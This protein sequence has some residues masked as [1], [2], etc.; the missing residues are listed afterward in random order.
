MIAV[1]EEHDS[2]HLEQDL[3][4][5]KELIASGINP[6]I[7][8]SHFGRLRKSIS[9]CKHDFHMPD[10]ELIRWL[11]ERE[12]LLG[13]F[14][15]FSTPEELEESCRALNFFQP[16]TFQHLNGEEAFVGALLSEPQC[17]ALLN[18]YTLGWVNQIR[19]RIYSLPSPMTRNNTFHL[20]Q[21]EQEQR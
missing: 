8:G 13:Y 15:P 21:S 6:F 9:E 7:L 11:D 17:L 1:E 14:L 19:E 10:F 2:C 20:F 5:T 16:F 4:K 18:D 12:A 3:L